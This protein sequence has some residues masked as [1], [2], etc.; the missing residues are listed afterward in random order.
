VKTLFALGAEDVQG[1]K[2]LLF[3]GIWFRKTNRWFEFE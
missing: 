3:P 1:D 2:I